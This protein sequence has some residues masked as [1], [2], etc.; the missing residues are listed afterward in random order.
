VRAHIKT[1]EWGEY[2]KRANNGEHDVYMSG[3][4]GDTA[5]PDDFLSPNLS[6]AANRSGVK[7]CNRDFDRLLDQPAPRRMRPA[8][9]RSTSRPS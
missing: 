8:A 6:C 5:D 9:P 1:Y 2:L 3:W 4:S 7:F